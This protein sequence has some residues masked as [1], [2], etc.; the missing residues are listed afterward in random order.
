MPPLVVARGARIAIRGVW[1]GQT[2]GA[3]PFL[4][5]LPR[6]SCRRGFLLVEANGTI[7]I[8]ANDAKVSALFDTTLLDHNTTRAPSAVGGCSRM[9]TTPLSVLPPRFIRAVAK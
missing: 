8:W 4:P 1:A 3:S 5:H 2:I 9:A 7:G 6:C